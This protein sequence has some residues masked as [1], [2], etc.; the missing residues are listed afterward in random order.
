MQPA[1]WR[2]DEMIRIREVVFQYVSFANKM[3]SKCQMGGG[4]LLICYKNCDFDNI[5]FGDVDFLCFL[6]H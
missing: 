6:C 2:D 1:D 4:S 5:L 3:L